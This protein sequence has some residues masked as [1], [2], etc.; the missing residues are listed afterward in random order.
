MYLGLQSCS[1]V[2][3]DSQKH[4]NEWMQWINYFMDFENVVLKLMKTAILLVLKR[5]DMP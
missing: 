5:G 4:K 3:Y 2:Y 1:S